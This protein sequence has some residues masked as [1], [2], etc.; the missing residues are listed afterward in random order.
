[1][2]NNRFVSNNLVEGRLDNITFENIDTRS[3]KYARSGIHS[4]AL[5]K[6]RPYAMTCLIKN[7][8]AGEHFN[9]SVYRHISNTRGCL[10]V[11]AEDIEKFY[12]VQHNSCK[13][14]GSWEYLDADFIVPSGAKGQNLKVY[15]WNKGSDTAVYFDDLTIRYVSPN[16]PEVTNQKGSL[17]DKRDNKVYQTVKIGNQ[18]WMAEDLRTNKYRDSSSILSAPA[19]PDTAWKTYTSGA[20]T[21]IMNNQSIVIGRLYNWYTT[22]DPRGLAPAGWH[23]PSDEEWK[24]LERNLGMSSEEANKTSWRGSHEGEKLKVMRGT[25]GGWSD[26]GSIWTTNESGFSAM[27]YG[28]RMFDSSWG[29]PGAGYTGFWWTISP[30]IQQAWYRYLDYKN[31]N[32]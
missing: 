17:N 22:V 12:L 24:V 23:I 31:A 32:I 15:T 16:P 2:D 27:P 14:E 13:R 5:T 18:W 29:D 25:A 6:E 3:D 7:V 30:N 8:Q 10:V 26:Y 11:S 9:I 28:C 20:F 1:M 19:P 21:N 4:V